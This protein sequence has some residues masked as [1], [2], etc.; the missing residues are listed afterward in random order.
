M[1]IKYHTYIYIYIYIC[2]LNKIYIFIYILN[3]DIQGSLNKFPDLFVWAFLLIVH[4]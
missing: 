1:Y 3:N 2:V 4:T